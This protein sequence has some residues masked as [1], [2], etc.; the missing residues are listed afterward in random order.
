LEW[1]DRAGGEWYVAG[2]TLNERL[3]EPY[4]LRVDVIHSE[5]AAD[6]AGLI[7]TSCVL[8]LMRRSTT[9]R[10]AGIVTMVR[11]GTDVNHRT[12]AVLSIEPALVALLHRRDTRIFQGLTVPQIL[13]QV[14]GAGLRP[15][16]RTL[17]LR[18]AG[19]YPPRE[20][21][22]QYDETDFDFAHRLMEEEGIGYT[23][24]HDGERERLVLFDRP[25]HFVALEGE[26]G[27][28]L[29][30]VTRADAELDAAEGVARFEQITR[31]KPNRVQTRTFDWTHPSV[32]MIE[33][34]EMADAA[35]PPLETYVHDA[36]VTFSSYDHTY[37][38]HNAADQVRLYAERARRDA[39][40]CDGTG[41]ALDLRPG[42]RFE[43]TQHPRAELDRSWAVVAAEHR[44]QTHV[45]DDTDALGYVV[46]FTVLPA[47]VPWRP[48]RSRPRPR[49][50]GVQTATVVGPAGEEIHCDP[51][52]RVK[53]HFH[54]DRLGA[55][56][57]RSSCWIRV[58]QAMGGP[59]WGFSFIPR[60]GM[61][62]V[63]TFIEGNP[64]R[65][66]IT[67]VVYNG[68]N[69]PPYDYPIE[70]TRTT[71]KTSSSP[72]GGGFNELRFEDRAGEEEIWL[73]GER[74]WN[75]LIKRDH[76][77]TVGH[78]ETQ[79]VVVDRSRV[80]GHDETIQ[81]GH[82]RRRRVDHDEAVSI[83]V[84]RTKS[85]GANETVTIGADETRS[86]GSSSS[87]TVGQNLTQTVGQNVVRVAGMNETLTVGMSSTTS[88]VIDHSLRVGG[89]GKREIG[90]NLSEK[91]GGDLTQKIKGALTATVTKARSVTVGLVDQLTVGGAR[92]E[93][94]T[95][96]SAEQVGLDKTIVAGNRISLTC[97]DSS[98][99]LEKD[100]TITIA[101]KALLVVGESAVDIIGKIINLN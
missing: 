63:I 17:E 40:L 45:E 2:A 9:Q 41:S 1:I 80:V 18:L 33:G 66:L 37:G 56:D 55:R 96:I 19:S 76:N 75:T 100:G 36:P 93:T 98:I 32:P 14:I 92:N 3:N 15:F 69:P 24:D 51:H 62:V 70:K 90:K 44:Y 38:A 13:A 82:D 25:A 52:G 7:G 20:Y 42:R 49:I 74:D 73:H 21:T 95:G 97:G 34:T 5:P 31:V 30:Y 60:I 79:E 8:S 10:V 46:R 71:I 88:V 35:W 16:H 67:G 68:E 77:R 85:I 101:G 78:S 29:R 84:N 64:D 58:M 87:E 94:V 12:Q 89:D 83:G 6:A 57:E 86:V 91:V 65:P 81:V 50:A 99:T 47:D 54:W 11:E 61:E 43:L 72:G 59:G 22:V 53:V 27:S 39:R 23:F 28:L 48:D 4:R 26:E